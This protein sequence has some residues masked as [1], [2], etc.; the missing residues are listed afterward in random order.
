MKTILRILLKAT[1]MT[2][3]IF[4][5]VDFAGFILWA[6][7]GQRPVDDVYVGTVTTHVLRAFVPDSK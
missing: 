5:C 6:F 2:V 7:S 1:V 4:A 3:L